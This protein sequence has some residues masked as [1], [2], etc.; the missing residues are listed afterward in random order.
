[1]FISGFK[2]VLML[3]NK[4]SNI[5]SFIVDKDDEIIFSTF[6]VKK[7]DRLPIL[8]HLKNVVINIDVP[9]LVVYN[10]LEMF[11]VIAQDASPDADRVIIG[12][13]LL[14]KPL[15]SKTLS[16]LSVSP[17]VSEEKIRNVIK[18]I[19]L[20]S[21]D[22]FVYYLEILFFSLTGRFSHFDKILD[23][24][25]VITCIP[26][27]LK[28]NLPEVL[29]E[30]D[31]SDYDSYAQEINKLYEL[32]K[33]GNVSDL[34]TMLDS[35]LL[36]RSHFTESSKKNYTTF[37]ASTAFFG[38]AALDSGVGYSEV[39]SIG[40]TLVR[41]AE[42][43][44]N[45]SEFFYLLHRMILGFATRVQ[46]ENL[47]KRR[48]QS[49]NMAIDYIDKSLNFP[50]ALNDVS[51]YVNHSRSYFSQLF[52][53]EMGISLQTYINKKKIEEA[54]RLLQFSSMSIKEISNSLAFC[55]QS[56]FT[57]VFKSVTNTTPIAYRKQ[58]RE[59]K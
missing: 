12:P 21:S 15:A 5:T 13:V 59:E 11:G 10:G 54:E 17:Y 32:V 2:K 51:K 18:N 55:S 25:L 39:Y 3:F 14:V 44:N 20:L 33:E 48:H 46:E 37:V 56:Y 34:E 26:E 38:K 58:F 30:G 9:L 52:S 40:S 47:R 24:K 22:K 42:L 7:G 49:I 29:F 43:F 1:M 27:N 53:K 31:I 36:I 28:I 19:P 45:A 4:F 35:S 6:G 23:G 50:L 8:H 41:R 16:F 57:E